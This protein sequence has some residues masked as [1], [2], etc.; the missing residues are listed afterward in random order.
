PNAAAIPNPSSP[1]TAISPR[2]VASRPRVVPGSETV[3][4]SA[5][6]RTTD[7]PIVRRTRNWTGIWRVPNPGAT[8]SSV[9]NRNDMRNTRII[10]AVSSRVVIR[11]SSE[12]SRDALYE[13]GGERDKLLQHPGAEDGERDDGGQ[14]LRDEDQRH[15]LDLSHD[16]ENADD[17]PDQERQ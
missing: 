13:I 12:I 15:L 11:F 10:H 3:A 9:P 16:L 1:P 17:Q 6:A 8:S 4:L 5:V 14:D 2:L 7:R